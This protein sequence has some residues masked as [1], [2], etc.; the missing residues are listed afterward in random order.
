MKRFLVILP[1]I[2][3]FTIC[4]T[5]CSNNDEETPSISF[6]TP[7]AIGTWTILSTNGSS[8]W[9]W[10]KENAQLTFRSDGT[11][12]TGFS[13]EDSY[14]IE[15]GQINTYYK[16][17]NEPMLK[18]TPISVEGEVY[19]VKVSGTLDESNLS[20]IIKMKKKL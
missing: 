1:V 8:E 18:Y 2:V 17:T 14:K 9:Y 11:C 19:T 13:M 16:E 7:T 3:F 10:I 20:I 4:L 15:S 5:S 6:D 12:S